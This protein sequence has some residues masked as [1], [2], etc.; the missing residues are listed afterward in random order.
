[1]RRW[2]GGEGER[3]KEKEKKERQRA[4]VCMYVCVYVCM[5]VCMY[6]G[7]ILVADNDALHFATLQHLRH[8]L[9]PRNLF[10]G[11]LRGE[12]QAQGG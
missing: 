9:L 10:P 8:K 2:R 12:E 3:E 6:L 4:S 5:Y 7:H 1:V 11:R